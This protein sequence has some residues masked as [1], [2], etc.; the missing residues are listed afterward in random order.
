MILH[1][2]DSPLTHRSIDIQYATRL[3]FDIY[4]PIPWWRE[5]SPGT[6]TLNCLKSCGIGNIVI[7][8]AI[9]QKPSSLRNPIVLEC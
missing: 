9:I 2:R 8:Y 3:L 4:Q 7:P 5:H 1:L 6:T